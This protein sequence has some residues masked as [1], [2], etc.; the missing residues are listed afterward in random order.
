MH[1]FPNLNA[2]V[3]ISKGMPALKLC[4]IFLNWWCWLTLVDLYNGCKMDVI[5]AVE[6]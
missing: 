2:L 5:V 3:A 1:L 4:S 6:A